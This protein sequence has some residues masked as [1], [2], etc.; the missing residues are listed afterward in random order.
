VQLSSHSKFLISS[1]LCFAVVPPCSSSLPTNMQNPNTTT[2]F[3]D[4]CTDTEAHWWSKLKVPTV[5]KARYNS[6]KLQ[7]LH[8]DSSHSV[9][10][11]GMSHNSTLYI[12]KCSYKYLYKHKNTYSKWPPSTLM[13]LCSLRWPVSWLLHHSISIYYSLICVYKWKGSEISRLHWHMPFCQSRV[14]CLAKQQTKT[15]SQYWLHFYMC[16]HIYQLIYK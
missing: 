13:Q 11:N 6:Y 4:D 10:R 8:C 7:F 15:W 2:I 3:R 12:Y 16:G 14:S 9:M 5:K 1:F